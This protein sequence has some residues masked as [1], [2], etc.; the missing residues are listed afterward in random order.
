M[1]FVERERKRGRREK[2]KS[3]VKKDGDGPALRAFFKDAAGPGVA[4]RAQ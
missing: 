3:I 1:V 2:S 4:A